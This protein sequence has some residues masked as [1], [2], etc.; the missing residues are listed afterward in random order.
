[1][2]FNLNEWYEEDDINYEDYFDSSDANEVWSNVKDSMTPLQIN[3][4][5]VEEAWPALDEKTKKQILDAYEVENIEEVPLD[6]LDDYECFD[7]LQDMG[8]LDFE[9]DNAKYE[10]MN[11]KEFMDSVADSIAYHRD[12]MGYNGLSWKDFI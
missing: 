8:L 11:S 12:P 4:M 5:W 6:E 9:Y 3:K 10:Y 2:K 1:M 7:D